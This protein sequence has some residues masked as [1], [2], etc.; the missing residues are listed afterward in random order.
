MNPSR[1]GTDKN[2]W[3]EWSSTSSASNRE[4]FAAQQRYHAGLNVA[5]MQ[6]SHDSLPRY[7]DHTYR[8]FSTYI[9]EGNRIEKHKKSDRNFPARLHVI[10]SNEQYSHIISWMPHGRAWKVKNKELLV[11]E[12]IP[13]FFGQSKFASFAR[14]LSGWG[15]KRLHQTG[16]DFGCYYHECFLRGHPRLTALMRRVSTGQGKVTPNMHSEPDFYLIAQQ[17]PLETPADVP[18]RDNKRVVSKVAK[19]SVSGRQKSQCPGDSDVGDEA[20]GYKEDDDPLMTRKT[21][22]PG[23]DGMSNQHQWDPFDQEIDSTHLH[24]QEAA[25]RAAMNH[26][27]SLRSQSHSFASGGAKESESNAQAAM[28]YDPFPYQ[29]QSG[30]YRDRGYSDPSPM[31]NHRL[32]PHSAY[33]MHPAPARQEYYGSNVNQYAAG[34]SHQAAAA[35]G[36]YYPPQHH[37]SQSQQQQFH[38][39]DAHS[40]HDMSQ[41]HDYW[42][43]NPNYNNYHSAQGGQ[44]LAQAQDYAQAPGANTTTTQPHSPAQG[45]RNRNSPHPLPTF[46]PLKSFQEDE[47]ESD[48]KPKPQT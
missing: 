28:N 1:E 30:S 43:R 36:Y 11:E 29:Q 23:M 3:S 26:F 21:A 18:D 2:Q 42:Y 19:A 12:V 44:G 41:S 4:E 46:S 40:H 45:D 10:L 8:D 5:A 38:Q 32:G 20:S 7:A 37:L 31:P 48:S 35:A 33:S 9:K 25:P 13:K 17:Y 47:G 16:A 24:H 15:F 22:E 34:S 14:Q 27:F 39:H 6:N